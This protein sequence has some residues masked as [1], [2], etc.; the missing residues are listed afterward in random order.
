M[1]EGKIARVVLAEDPKILGFL[2][3]EDLPLLETLHVGRLP[4]AW[5]PLETT[6]EE[7][8][9]LRA[10]LERVSAHGRALSLFDFEYLWEVYKPPEQ[11]RW[12]FYTLPILSQ[13]RLVART[14]LKLER[15]PR[16][17]C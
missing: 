14:D 15:P 2:L 11:R 6:T 3:A 9:I 12:G 7:E 4:E 13:E 17:C 8:M 16:R 1:A 5:Q 10:P